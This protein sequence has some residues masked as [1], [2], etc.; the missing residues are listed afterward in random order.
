MI[1]KLANDGKECHLILN[2]LLQSSRKSRALSA[3]PSLWLGRHLTHISNIYHSIP[4]IYQSISPVGLLAFHTSML[5]V[6]LEVHAFHT[7]IMT[8]FL[9]AAIL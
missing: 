3:K 4:P 6:L 1:F 8:T 9:L 5:M 7:G 2:F